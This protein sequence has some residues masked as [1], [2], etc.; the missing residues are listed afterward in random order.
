MIY[1]WLLPMIYTEFTWF[2]KKLNQTNY[3]LNDYICKAVIIRSI[4]ELRNSPV[5]WLHESRHAAHV[6]FEASVQEPLGPK[7]ILKFFLHFGG[8][9]PGE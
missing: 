3:V 9:L 4:Y 6:Q 1:K 8:I 7:T 2:V 5:K